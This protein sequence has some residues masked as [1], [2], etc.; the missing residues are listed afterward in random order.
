MILI[1]GSTGFVGRH[2]VEELLSRGK[3]IRCLLRGPANLKILNGFNVEICYGDVTNPQSL[4]AVLENVEAVVHL[5][6]IIKE[7]RQATFEGVNYLGTRNVVQVAK[8]NN[9]K[10]LIYMSNLGTGPDRSYPL[11]YT[12]WCAEEEVKKCSIDFTI[13]RPSIMFGKGDGFV[14]VLASIVKKLPLVPV[15]GSGRTK[16]QLISVDD[17]ATCVAKAFEDKHT[18]NRIIPLGGPEHL[19]FEDIIDMIIRSL[20]LRRPKFHIP[21]PLM[22][23]IVWGMEK[24][25]T[26]PPLTSAQL[27]M[28]SRDNITD[29]DIVE[30]FFGFKPISLQER[31]GTILQ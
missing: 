31:I 21:R 11:L 4:E 9:V 17:V 1:T 7:A 19:S 5:V 6:A 13:L 2:V 25:L 26:T 29:V 18:I 30:K 15:I 27:A 14:T 8:M 3:E 16:F 24:V 22:Q 28:L 20:R 10:R 23:P 12:K